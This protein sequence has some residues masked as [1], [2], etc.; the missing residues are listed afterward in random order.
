M[1]RTLNQ[2]MSD[3]HERDIAEWIGGAQQKGSG[4]QW[5]AQMDVVNGEKTTPYALAA[6]GKATLGKSISITRDMW[7]KAVAQTFNKIPTIWLR[8]YR[9]E[10]LREVSTDLVV[11]ERRDFLEILEAARKWTEHN[12][13]NIKAMGQKAQESELLPTRVCEE[14]GTHYYISTA[15]HH[16]RLGH[17]AEYLHAR[18]RDTCKF[19]GAPCDCACHEHSGG[20]DCCR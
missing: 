10:S 14:Q 2:Q 9:D 3:A 6:D 18:C 19:C 17:G 5:S 16:A 8:F 4:N 15:C 20:C 1:S 12:N 11:I 7:L 13:Q